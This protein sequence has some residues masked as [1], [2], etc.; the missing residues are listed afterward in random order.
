MRAKWLAIALLVF[1]LSIPAFG[2]SWQLQAVL[3]SMQRDI[4]K[5]TTDVYRISLA[6]DMRDVRSDKLDLLDTRMQDFESDA[7]DRNVSNVS[8][9]KQQIQDSR[10]M[11]DLRSELDGMKGRLEDVANADQT[12]KLKALRSEVD[13]LR[14]QVSELRH[15]IGRVA[16]PHRNTTPN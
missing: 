13:S 10:D 4:S 14:E 7:K 6:L 15:S 3:N 11:I 16:A 8:I 1:S 5:L 12:D 2:Q 9:L